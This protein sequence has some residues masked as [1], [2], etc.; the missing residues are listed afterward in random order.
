MTFLFSQEETNVK[1]E[2][3]NSIYLCAG[4]YGGIGSINFERRFLKK[5]KAQVIYGLGIG[6][7]RLLDYS[8]AL[9]PDITIPFEIGA[10]YGKKHGIQINIAQIITSVV[11]ADYI[12]YSKTRYCNIHL[13]FN[14][15]YSYKKSNKFSYKLM[16]SP[17]LEYYKYYRNW[18]A[19]SI[20]YDF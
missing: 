13:G 17:I 16:Y 14:L 1:E 12:S 3:K 9:N 7:Y 5:Q 2:K 18:F 11:K 8:R 15:G 19:I 10:R 20:G 4:G 6:S